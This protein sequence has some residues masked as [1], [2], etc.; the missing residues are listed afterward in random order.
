MSRNNSDNELMLL[1][2][3]PHRL[4]SLP[5]SAARRWVNEIYASLYEGA[6]LEAAVFD[7]GKLL[8]GTIELIRI[9]CRDTD[10]VLEWWR[11]GAAFQEYKP[12]LKAE[13][14]QAPF[15]QMRNE[16]CLSVFGMKGAQSG[17]LVSHAGPRCEIVV[18]LQPFTQAARPQ[19]YGAQFSEMLFFILP[20]L[21]QVNAL[22]GKLKQPL[23][24]IE[25]AQSLL[26]LV[27]L[28][29]IAL[30]ERNQVV[31]CNQ[32]TGT[33]LQRLLGE[34]GRAMSSTGIQSFDG[35]LL[36]FDSGKQALL[37]KTLEVPATYL[38]DEQW[39]RQSVRIFT[40]QDCRHQPRLN[41]PILAALYQLSSAEIGVCQWVLA[42]KEPG[43]IATLQSRSINTIKSQLRSIYRKT[44]TQNT[45]QLA[46]RLFF[47][48][49][50][51]VGR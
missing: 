21:A 16:Y 8:N 45:A 5:L 46:R 1:Q 51:W 27:P 17:I 39:G 49:A 3:E 22:L 26:Q 6:R 24:K 35:H 14:D 38:F 13:G 44:A 29:L 19:A 9:T 18:A 33:M 20:Q 48:P 23:R 31:A 43:D 7:L 12:E 4:A 10:A 34:G 15:Q 42:G 50:Y 40:L 2:D 37:C 25:V 11:P 47:N 28:P 30:D 32:S 36:K 41:G